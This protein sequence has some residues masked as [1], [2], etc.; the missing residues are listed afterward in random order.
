MSRGHPRVSVRLD[1]ALLNRV[2]ARAR[3]E[4][5]HVSDILRRSLAIYTEDAEACG[6]MIR[7]TPYYR[8][9]LRK[10]LHDDYP[11]HE[12]AAVLERFMQL[13]LDGSWLLTDREE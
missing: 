7:L 8:G 5:I 6:V 2:T 1:P 13:A 11:N 4:A 9:Q 10:R 12:P 3:A